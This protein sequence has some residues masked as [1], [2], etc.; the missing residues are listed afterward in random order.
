MPDVLN[1]LTAVTA[2]PADQKLPIS[3]VIPAYNAQAYLADAIASIRAQT[4]P[5]EEIIV[6]DDGSTDATCDIARALGV[7]LHIQQNSGVSAARNTGV[8]LATSPWVAFL[9]ADDLWE[10]HKLERQWLA[11]QAVPSS[12]MSITGSSYFNEHGALP[13]GLEAI[14][15]FRR[16]KLIGTADASVFLCEP[17]SYARTLAR[18]NFIVHASILVNREIFMRTGGYDETMR[19]SEDLDWILRAATL[20]SVVLVKEPLAKIRTHTTNSSKN[21]DRMIL[22]HINVGI[23]AGNYPEQYPPGVVAEFENLRAKSYVA[24]GLCLLRSLSV[25]EAKQQF[26][27]SWKYRPNARAACFLAIALVAEHPV[28]MKILK[29]ARSFTKRRTTGGEEA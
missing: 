15:E 28:G 18:V 24:A 29:M 1:L 3:V 9:D 27:E 11:L 21:W 20:T 7:T 13:G 19:Y 23:K 25:T 17:A 14:P 16:V 6:I 26:L 8:R 12:F 10:P 2:G 22:S 5:P 4:S